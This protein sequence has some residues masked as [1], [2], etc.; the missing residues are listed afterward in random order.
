MPLKRSSKT[1]HRKTTSI[2]FRRISLGLQFGD[3]ARWPRR[4]K[5]YA[6]SRGPTLKE[7]V[8]DVLHG[9][10]W[11]HSHVRYGRDK[12]GSNLLTYCLLDSSSKAPEKEA[13]LPEAFARLAA[14][15]QPFKAKEVLRREIKSVQESD[16]HYAKLTPEQ[17]SELDTGLVAYLIGKELALH[18]EVVGSGFRQSPCLQ[19]R[20]S[21]PNM[22]ISKK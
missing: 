15:L 2:T 12:L 16:D 14:A 8:Y 17:R 4:P 20:T 7:G 5:P 6:K 21:K 3:A 18:R 22:P 10:K 11:A 1:I 9:I 13:G 19:L